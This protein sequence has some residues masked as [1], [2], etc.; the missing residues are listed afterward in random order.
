MSFINRIR[1]EYEG[2]RDELSRGRRGYQETGKIIQNIRQ[3]KYDEGQRLSGLVV[4]ALETEE[5]DAYGIGSE[6]YL[7]LHREDR[8]F[9][10]RKRAKS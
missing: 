8:A 5:D 6:L 10:K 9:L 3:G 2:F 1:E 7:I 4:L